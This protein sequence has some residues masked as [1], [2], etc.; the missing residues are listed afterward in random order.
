MSVV[1]WSFELQ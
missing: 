1:L